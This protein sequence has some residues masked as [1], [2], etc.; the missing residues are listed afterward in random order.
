MAGQDIPLPSFRRGQGERMEVHAQA[1]GRS[2]AAAGGSASGTVKQTGTR[3]CT[4]GGIDR[5]MLRLEA[6][7]LRVTKRVQ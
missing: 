7:M 4:G 5:D 3:T 6:E 2:N 1:G